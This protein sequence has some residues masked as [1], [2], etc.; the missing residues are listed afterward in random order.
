MIDFRYHLI[1]LVGVILALALGI[2][3][4]SGFLGGP[5]LERLQG[6]IEDLHKDNNRLQDE[7]GRLDEQIEQGETFANAVAPTLTRGK[8]AG[9][10]IVF[11]RLARTEERLI[12]GVRDALLDSGAQ[13]ITEIT[14]TDKFALE[15]APARDE[16]ALIIGS[17]TTEDD[18]LLEQ[19]GV[20]IGERAGAAASDPSRADSPS[21][22]IAQQRF[23]SLVTEL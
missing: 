13:L 3:A 16:L 12:E 17:V 9:E 1:S 22:G 15:S 14:L 7:I 10:E 11:V 6:D 21:G 23:E 8:L 5:L 20:F 19:A 2:L 4:G 18:A